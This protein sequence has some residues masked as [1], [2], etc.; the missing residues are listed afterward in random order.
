MIVMKDWIKLVG[1]PADGRTV[2]IASGTDIYA[3]R[4]R[5]RAVPID[6]S[7]PSRGRRRHRGRP[8]RR[9][10]ELARYRRTSRG[11]G[12]MLLPR[13]YEYVAPGSA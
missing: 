6:P 11:V 13:R 2:Q 1:G 9:G 10:T 8:P 5:L 4:V 3:A 7:R 12:T